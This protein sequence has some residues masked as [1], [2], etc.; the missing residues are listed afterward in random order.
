MKHRKWIY[1]QKPQ[2]YGAKC[3]KCGGPNIEWSEWERMIWRYD[4]QVDTEGR[5][6]IFD[7][8]IPVMATELLGMSLA[9]LYFKD[10]TIRYPHLRKH[11]T[12]YTKVKPDYMAEYK[13]REKNEH[14]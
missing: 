5:E 4:C 6:S 12:I 10:N 7:G 14:I 9:R 2:E 1:V 11:K 3:D 8:P 13:L